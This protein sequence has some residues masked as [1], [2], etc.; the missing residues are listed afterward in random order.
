MI[1]YHASLRTFGVQLWREVIFLRERYTPALSTYLLYVYIIIIR[2]KGCMWDK[3]QRFLLIRPQSSRPWPRKPVVLKAWFTHKIFLL[4]PNLDLTYLPCFN[5]P[6]R[7]E[8]WDFIF[9]SRTKVWPAR[10]SIF[11]KSWMLLGRGILCC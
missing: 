9:R 11:I 6:A 10:F 1:S 2:M 7:I 8:I 3:S 5:T 4:T